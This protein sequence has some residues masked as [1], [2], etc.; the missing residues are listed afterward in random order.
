MLVAMI[1]LKKVK[2]QAL[3]EMLPAV[4]KYLQCAVHQAKWMLPDHPDQRTQDCL[5]GADDS[6]VE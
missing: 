2:D 1:G 6:D 5:T 3:T 4:Q